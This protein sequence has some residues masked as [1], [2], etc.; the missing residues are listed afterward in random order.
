MTPR[1][2]RPCFMCRCSHTHGSCRLADSTAGRS[3]P[4]VSQDECVL[5]PACNQ[6]PSMLSGLLQFSGQDLLC[7]SGTGPLVRH[8]GSML[9]GLPQVSG[10][11]LL[12]LLLW[13]GAGCKACWRKP[14]CK[15]LLQVRQADGCRAREPW[16][17]LACSRC[18]TRQAMMI[19]LS[20][21]PAVES[22]LPPT[23]HM[24]HYPVHTSA[25]GFLAHC[26]PQCCCSQGPSCVRASLPAAFLCGFCC[27]WFAVAAGA[28]ACLPHPLLHRKER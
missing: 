23:P 19:R 1:P 14:S 8:A 27:G 6:K 28:V 21:I 26:T 13:R 11:D 4:F 25:I 17:P 16:V 12:W 3:A 10:Q 18:S 15:P 2:P 20:S 9:S 22:A 24:G 7:C 5:L